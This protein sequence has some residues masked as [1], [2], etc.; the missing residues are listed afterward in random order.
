[1]T[2]PLINDWISV[3]EFIEK[4]LKAMSET[5]FRY[6][7]AHRDENGAT[8]FV[9]KIGS[10]SIVISPTRFNEWIEGRTRTK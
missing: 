3:K 8:E 7:I 4:H 10:R 1:M 5:M 9:R 6:I 2:I